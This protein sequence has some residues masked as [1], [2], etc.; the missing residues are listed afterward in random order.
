MVLKDRERPPVERRLIRARDHVNNFWFPVNETLHKKIR[1]TLQE[2]AY[3][4]VTSLVKD[5]RGDFSLFMFCIREVATLLKEDG[6]E[7]PLTQHPIELLEWAGVERL[8]HILDIETQ[9]IS[10]HAMEQMHHYQ[11]AQ[12]EAAL[13]SST[14]SQVLSEKFGVDPDIAFTTSLLRH[15]GYALIAWN[16]ADIYHQA[17]LSV[18]PTEPLDGVITRL[19]GFSPSSLAMSV[20]AEW[21]LAPYIQNAVKTSD[22]AQLSAIFNAE[23]AA[24]TKSLLGIC[25]I[26][27]A[28]ARAN[29]PSVHATA[30]TDWKFARNEIHRMIGEIGITFIAEKLNQAA[31]SYLEFTPQVFKGA[32]ILDPVVHQRTQTAQYDPNPYVSRCRLQLREELAELYSQMS[33][34]DV[35][36]L[37]RTLVRHIIPQTAFTRGCVYTVDP[38]AALLVPQLGIGATN[39]ALLKAKPANLSEADTDIIVRSYNTPELITGSAHDTENPHSYLARCIGHTQRYGVLYLET[40]QMLNEMLMNQ[41]RDEFNAIA[42]TLTDCLALI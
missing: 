17:L 20:I 1:A 21:G 7:V 9:K 36:T 24:I 42:L 34:Q 28:L 33:K 41:T 26:S 3:T 13:I 19:L 6:H 32:F 14:A 8:K 10:P 39:I 4:E 29:N 40:P 27:E 16:Y 2:G 35:P 5:I 30:K 12:I 15:L 22:D 11:K 23:S 18:R 38:G 25:K 31:A 37:I